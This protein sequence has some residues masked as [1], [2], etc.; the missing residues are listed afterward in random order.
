MTITVQNLG[1]ID[2]ATFDI[3]EMTVLCGANNFGK[4]YVTYAFYGLMKY[5]RSS[6][7]LI[8]ISLSSI[9]ELLARGVVTIPLHHYLAALP[10]SVLEASDAYSNSLADVFAADESHFKD[11]KISMDTSGIT[12]AMFRD[13]EGDI[14]SSRNPIFHLSFSAKT[15]EVT[16]RQIG[17]TKNR[18]PL[19][20][21]F[22]RHIVS[23]AV[24]QYLLKPV[25][26]SVYISSSERTGVVM[27]Y[28]ELDFTRNRIL[29]LLGQKGSDIAS[30]LLYDEFRGEYPLPVRDNVDFIRNLPN[31]SGEEKRLA[32]Q[33]P[34]ILEKLSDVVAG[35]FKATKDG[36]VSY[37]PSKGV[38]LSVGES[39]SSIRSLLD[40]AFYLRYVAEPG[41]MLMIDEPELNLHPSNQRKL[42][43]LLARLVNCGVKVFMTTHSDYIVK[44]INTLLL[45]KQEGNGFKTIAKE[46]GYAQEELLD[47]SKVHVYIANECP[48]KKPGNTRK[49]LCHT[50]TPA[51]ISQSMGIEIKSFDETIDD[52]NRIQD[53]IL[54]EAR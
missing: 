16:I 29:E 12:S 52:M 27:F 14:S 8:P 19:R 54:W 38:K 30:R 51:P 11:A 17:E 1:N 41:G 13:S 26:P 42:A 2:A 34:E 40:V 33:H 39:S 50:F 22:V 28:R 20:P 53:R 45:L 7:S 5:L 31:L 44:E 3:G 25:I 24:R 21:S 15:L 37:H 35:S 43:R 6:Y 23:D 10:K 46:E 4:T 9:E 49:T 18:L 32:K 36:F 48:L 47:A